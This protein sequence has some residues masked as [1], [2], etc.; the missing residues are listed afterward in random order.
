MGRIL[1]E[2]RHA[3]HV[4]G[5]LGER[6]GQF[7]LGPKQDNVVAKTVAP[8]RRSFGAGRRRTKQDPVSRWRNIGTMYVHGSARR[9]RAYGRDGRTANWAFMAN[10]DGAAIFAA[11]GMTAGKRGIAQWL[12]KTNGTNRSIDAN[13]IVVCIQLKRFAQQGLVPPLAMT[14]CFSKAR[15]QAGPGTRGTK[16]SI[17]RALLGRTKKFWFRHGFARARAFGVV[18][19]E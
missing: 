12:V 15:G 9:R 4:V 11:K 17:P 3:S 7:G 14:K 5:S 18:S 8:G 19:D 1:N 2:C 6:R 13:G 10:H 16:R